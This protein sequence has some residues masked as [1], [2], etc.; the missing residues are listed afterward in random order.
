MAARAARV[1]KVAI[2]ATLC[3]P[4]LLPDV[5]D[6]LLAAFLAE[7]DVD[8]RR[9]AAVGIEEALEQQVVLQRIDV[10]ELEDVADQGAAGR[11][12]G[13]G[14]DAVLQGEAHEVPDDEEIAGE[15]H[16]A[17]DAQLVL[18]PVPRRLRRVVAVALA[19]PLL[20]QLA[21]V[22]LR[23]LA[24]GRREDGEV[25]G[26]EVELES[27]SRRRFPGC[28]RRRRRG[29]G[30]RRVHLLGR[31]GRRTDRCR[32][33][34][35]WRRLQRL[36]GVDAQQHVVGRSVGL[37]QVVGVAGGHQRQ[38]EPVGDVD[39]SLGAAALDVQ[40]VVLNLDVEVL[41]ED[42]VE[43]CGQLASPRPSGP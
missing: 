17:D 40:A 42:A 10:A 14:R 5:G 7:V 26:L 2:W 34:G 28:A 30:K 32:S 16:P 3:S 8:V 29:S 11:A 38:A 21:Q 20:A 22:V 19:Q 43:P 4:Y 35:G 1:P 15:A 27:R 18:Q 25:P 37:A 6:D 9:L 39:G 23:L 33:A 13:A 24:V 31:R 41:A 36:A 12:A